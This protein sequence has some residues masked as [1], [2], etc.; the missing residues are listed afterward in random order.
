MS[1]MTLSLSVRA[2]AC[3]GRG[4][5][6]PPALL[7][8]P[9]SRRPASG[10]LSEGILGVANHEGPRKLVKGVYEGAA[11]QVPL[12]PRTRARL[13]RRKPGRRGSGS[14]KPPDSSV[15]GQPVHGFWVSLPQRAVVTSS[16]CGHPSWSRR[17][18]SREGRRR[19]RCQELGFGRRRQRTRGS[20]RTAAVL[21]DARRRAVQAIVGLARGQEHACADWSRGERVVERK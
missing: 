2:N 19:L 16:G 1:S 3:S 10:M 4:E 8:W 12:L 7:P 13:R 11:R 18:T 5:L 6:P 14:P 21:G 15:L 9:S 17:T 20:R